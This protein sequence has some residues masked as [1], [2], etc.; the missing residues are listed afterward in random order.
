MYKK[1]NNKNI[2]VI[3]G[4]L[5]IVALLFGFLSYLVTT[6]RKLSF[7]E[8][9]IKDGTLF[10]VDIITSPVDYVRE[11]LNDSS[12]QKK[13]YEDY[14]K[15]QQK[16]YEYD[17]LLAEKKELEKELRDMKELLNLEVTLQ[18]KTHL[19]GTVINRNLGYWYQTITVDK[20]KN[21]GVQ[22][23]MAVV[24]AQGLIGRTTK[25]SH[26]NTTVEL[27][28]S[29][30]FTSKVSIKIEQG[31]NFVYG[32]L[33]GYDDEKKVFIVEGIAEN[34]EIEKDSIVTTTGL[35]SIYPSGI[36][37]GRVSGVTTDN[38]DLGKIIEVKS[39]VDFDNL[40]YV[41]ILKREASE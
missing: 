36:F 24:S 16:A 20:G 26:F 41:T 6:S 12:E 34:I 33:S 14:K 7:V 10:L 32:L 35:G 25:T 37:I 8:A 2:Y 39:D 29:E 38:F 13:V 27:L 1:R 22:D 4:V 3:V 30:N 28:T 15:Y 9:A 21:N 31:E 11:K 5:F 40:S 23:N 17:L 19:N 18:E